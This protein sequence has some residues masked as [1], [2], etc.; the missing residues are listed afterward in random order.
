M[1]RSK[2]KFIVINKGSIQARQNLIT[3]NFINK[4]IKIHNGKSFK[5]LL[6][7]PEYVGHK[8]GEFIQTKIIP[9]YKNNVK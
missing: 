4:Q 9:K 8:F 2:W 6:V 5:Q 3:P 7:L 1:S